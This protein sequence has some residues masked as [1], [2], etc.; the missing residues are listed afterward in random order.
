[1]Q[2]ESVAECVVLAREDA[3]G[4][5]RLV[6]YVV[7]NLQY[8]QS[9]DGAL[10]KDL[11]PEHVSQWESVFDDLFDKIIEDDEQKATFY[12]KGWNSS[13]TD[14]QIPEE[15]IREW[16]NNTVNRILDLS[17][18]RVL[19]IG[20]GS[21]LMLFRI[22]PHC[23][24]YCAT[25]LAES[26]IPMLEKQLAVLDEK[27]PGVSLMQRA[28][29]DFSDLGEDSFDAVL[30]SSVVQYFPSIE[31][32]MQVLEGAVRIVEPGGF[33]FV[34]DVRNLALLEAFHA[35]VQL[36][37]AAA[38]LSVDE[39]RR[40]VKRQMRSERQL[41]IDPTFFMTLH[42]RLNKVREVEVQLLR[43]R[44]HNEEIKYRYDVIIH[45][46]DSRTEQPD[47]PW[48]DWEQEN[49]ELESLRQRLDGERPE[50]LG[51]GGVPNARLLEDLK[52]LDWL[53][54]DQPATVSDIRR[55]IQR[56]A[57]AGI[58]PEDFW[59][60]GEELGYDVDVT[61]A[62]TGAEGRF[63]AVFTRR[64]EGLDRSTRAFYSRL[65]KVEKPLREYAND[66]LKIKYEAGLQNEFAPK[67][68]P[69]LRSHLRE[70]LP[71]YMLPSAFVIMDGLPVT[72]NGK[73]DRQALPAPD[74]KR[75]EL[76]QEY[77]TPRN[78]VEK[79]LAQIWS[80][81]LGVERVG[82]EDNFFDL[83]GHSLLA[84]QIMSRVSDTFN[85]DVP[86]RSLFEEP[87][88][89]GLATVVEQHQSEHDLPQPPQ[90][91]KLSKLVDSV[92]QQLANL[93]QLPDE[94]VN[95]QLAV[96]EQ[97]TTRRGMK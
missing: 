34:G 70:R 5:K 93:M 55:E 78:E 72:A 79:A 13:Y 73:I 27:I 45:V 96:E 82:I 74:K 33:V 3:P 2:H 44:H 22:G 30:I 1:M 86:L 69:E 76:E 24:Q 64:E 37:R 28:A 63:D 16:T 38:S 39:L 94:Q 95:S 19:E 58:E 68:V 50:R 71:D 57:N 52:I 81:V 65:P 26:F 87:T 83:G 77:K 36:Y 75:P 61:W 51:V 8:L 11:V 54:K 88:V 32:L 6:A 7:P 67:A 18:K 20:S 97:A 31:Y 21:G 23:E 9:A 4:D 25:D 49:L 41:V 43:G 85:T 62:D 10:S 42:K 80:E 29:D 48:L 92:E 90:P 56:S 53:D 89:A 84:I 15:E 47:L 35:S 60:M 59:R 40:R 14:E 91:P 12:V 66:P 17:P 46:G